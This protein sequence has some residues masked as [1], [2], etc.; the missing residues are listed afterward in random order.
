MWDVRIG[1]VGCEDWLCG[2]RGLAVWDVRIGCVG[3]EDWLCGMRGLAVSDVRIGCVGYEQWHNRYWD[4]TL[5]IVKHLNR[6]SINIAQTER[7]K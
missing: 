3:C 2:M 1:C 4:S 5:C 6:M 7:D